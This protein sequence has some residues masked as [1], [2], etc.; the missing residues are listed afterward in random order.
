[1]ETTS[2]ACGSPSRTHVGGLEA[3]RAS[4]RDS[5]LALKAGTVLLLA[6]GLFVICAPLFGSPNHQDIARGLTSDG[7]PLSFSARYPL[8]T[9]ILGRN[10]LARLAYGG[11]VSLFVA[12]L[13]NFTSLALGIAVGV[14][15]GYYRGRTETLLMRITDV[16][17]AFPFVLGAFVLAAV[18]PAGITRVVVIITVLFWAYPARLIYGEVVRLRGRAFIEAADAAGSRGGATMRRHI[19][20][21]LFPLLVTYAPLNAAAAIMFESTLSYLGAG[22]NPPTPSW[23][24]MIADGQTALSYSPH[25]LLEPALFLAL[26]ILAFLLIGEGLKSRSTAVQRNSWLAV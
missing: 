26:T 2:T 1:M 4:W 18:L 24:N 16:A 13:S 6:L 19:L 22:I 10:E 23:G 25:L 8:G 14:V 11:R 3:L 5:P 20:P 9:D 12:L 17:L 7:Y 15:A 21:H